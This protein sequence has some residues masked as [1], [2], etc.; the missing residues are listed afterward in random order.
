MIHDYGSGGSFPVAFPHL[1]FAP[2]CLARPTGGAVC[3]A[4]VGWQ[5]TFVLLLKPGA[6]KVG[7]VGETT[8]LE[9]EKA[10]TAVSIPSVHPAS[11]S[12]S[13][14]GSCSH[15]K[16]WSFTCRFFLILTV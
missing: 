3:P 12:L 14:K 2:L 5:I 9:L 4:A 6:H 1:H 10:G 11:Y 8:A 16:L 7:V 13:E 15:P